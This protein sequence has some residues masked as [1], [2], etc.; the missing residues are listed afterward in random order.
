MGGQVVG[1]DVVGHHLG[2]V[3]GHQEPDA[4]TVVVRLIRD[5]RVAVD[6]DGAGTAAQ[7]T[8]VRRECAGDHDAAALVVTLVVVDAVPGDRAAV[9]AAVVRDRSAVLRREVAAE[10]VAGD[11]VVVGAGEDAECARE[12]RA[13]VGDEPVVGDVEALVVV[14]RCV[15]VAGQ[16][17][18]AD[19]D[20][21]V[22]AAV[23]L[24]LVVRDG[25]VANVL[26]EHGRAAL[27]RTR[28]GRSR[29]AIGDTAR[30]GVDV[31]RI[32]LLVTT[33]EQQAVDA[34][35]EVQRRARVA[36]HVLVLVLGDGKDAL[37]LGKVGR[38]GALTGETRSEGPPV[39]GV[40]AVRRVLVA[41]WRND[42]GGGPEL[43]GVDVRARGDVRGSYGPA[44][45]DALE[46]DLAVHHD[47]LEVR[48]ERIV[49]C[50]VR[51]RVRVDHDQLRTGVVSIAG[52]LVGPLDGPLYRAAAADRSSLDLRSDRL[53]VSTE[54]GGSIGCGVPGIHLRRVDADADTVRAI[55]RGLGANLIDVT[56]LEI[57]RAAAGAW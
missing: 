22:G 51:G 20:R 48:R 32:A 13:A 55:R 12:V 16:I 15:G 37:S 38:A 41:S 39:I 10:V 52:V 44:G 42:L 14:A 33:G 31:A 35:P 8:V 5:Q 11:R 1:D 29:H 40:T 46:L 43:G 18:R 7:L 25:E 19:A 57:C 6:R 34:G 45:A 21:A 26:I 56:T 2:E 24:D 30:Q 27:G 54:S 4:S 47:V 49:R 36:W 9:G 50:V 3:A 23:R 17:G 53:R 28:A